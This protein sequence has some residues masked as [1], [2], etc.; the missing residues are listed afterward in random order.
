MMKTRGGAK[1]RKKHEEVFQYHRNQGYV[2]LK[3]LEKLGWEEG[4]GLG[5]GKGRC[6]KPW[7]FKGHFTRKE[8]VIQTEDIVWQLLKEPGQSVCLKIN[9]LGLDLR[10]CSKI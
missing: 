9:I 3:L 4:K 5:D 10:A 7:G 6:G 2:G 8:E 1:Q